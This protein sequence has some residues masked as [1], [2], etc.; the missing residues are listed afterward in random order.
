MDCTGQFPGI[1]QG[2]GLL[3]VPTYGTSGGSI[4]VS[5][6]NHNRAQL[7][8]RQLYTTHDTTYTQQYIYQFILYLFHTHYLF[9]TT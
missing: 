2:Q 9:T 7:H 8:Y 3:R 4:L 5:V 6:Q 1:G